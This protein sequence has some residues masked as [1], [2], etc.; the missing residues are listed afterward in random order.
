MFSVKMFAC[1]YAGTHI[2]GDPRIK[3]ERKNSSVNTNGP[4]EKAEE[5]L[6]TRG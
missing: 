5:I 2:S 3:T 4:E 6:K 1:I